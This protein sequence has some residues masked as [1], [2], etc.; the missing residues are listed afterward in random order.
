M[1]EEGVS[2]AYHTAMSKGGGRGGCAQS[3]SRAYGMCSFRF[4]SCGAHFGPSSWRST[5]GISSMSRCSSA[6]P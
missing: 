4:C 2:V 5:G 3:A 1:R 6:V